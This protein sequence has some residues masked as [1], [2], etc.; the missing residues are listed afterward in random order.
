VNVAK[1]FRCISPAIVGVIA[2]TALV[3]VASPAYAASSPFT[4]SNRS[5]S[6]C[7]GNNSSGQSDI[8]PCSGSMSQI[9]QINNQTTVGGVLVSQFLNE[10]GK[11]LGLA[12]STGPQLVVGTCSSSSDHS[13]F[14]QQVS[15]SG[16]FVLLKNAHT[17][18]CAGTKNGGTGAGTLV[19]LNTCNSNSLTQ[20]WGLS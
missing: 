19:V 7:L 2:S 11:C 4:I 3:L 5:N 17:G 9:W 20:Q 8:G 15:T 10:K 16:G 1:F 18:T 12:G 6:M 14:W 13:Q